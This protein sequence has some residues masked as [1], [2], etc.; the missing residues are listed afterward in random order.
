M[1]RTVVL[2]AAALLLIASAVY[3]F[4]DIARPKATP[5]P[6]PGKVVFHTGL[7]IVPDSK[8]YE[9]RLQISQATL[10]RIREATTNTSA[11]TSMT[12]RIMQSSTR[13]V[14]AGIFM[15]LA[16]SFAGVWLAR[17]S[18]RRSQKGIAAVL[19]VVGMLGAATV[20]VRANAGP[21]GYY[22]WQNLPQNLTKGQPTRGGLDIEIVPGDDG[23]KL[24]I[25]VKSTPKLGEE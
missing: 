23:I 1:K 10:E 22:Y 4:G 14:M 7:Q 13:T 12:Q 15:F 8:S 11:N 16:I 21:P 25:P 24:I 18:Q 6:T 3:T 19:L 5:T 9:A 2:C 20:I 17:S